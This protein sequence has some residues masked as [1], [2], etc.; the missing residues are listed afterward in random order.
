MRGMKIKFLINL[1]LLCCHRFFFFLLII[2]LIKSNFF[3]HNYLSKSRAVRNL[4]RG[5]SI[6]FLRN[7]TNIMNN[8]KQNPATIQQAAAK[9]NNGSNAYTIAKERNIIIQHCRIY[10]INL[11]GTIGMQ[12]HMGMLT[13]TE[14][15]IFLVFLVRL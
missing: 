4:T 8:N 1:C 3:H 6:I 14:M 12:T 2:I 15:Q 13:P 10:L 5:R 7:I 11:L 9:P